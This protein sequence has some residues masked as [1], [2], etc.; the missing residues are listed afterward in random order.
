M[1]VRLFG[2]SKLTLGV[3]VSVHACLSLCGPVMEWQ[4][5]GL[6]GHRKWMDDYFFNNFPILLQIYSLL[7]HSYHSAH[8]A[9]LF[10]CSYDFAVWVMGELTNYINKK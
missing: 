8:V 10:A 1:H 7:G 3:S 9:T 4:P 6:S 5:A 2:G